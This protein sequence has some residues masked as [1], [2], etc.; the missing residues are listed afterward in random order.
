MT[1]HYN[2]TLYYV[3]VYCMSY[4]HIISDSTSTKLLL[5]IISRKKLRSHPPVSCWTKNSAPQTSWEQ[6]SRLGWPWT[7]GS[8]SA[9]TIKV[10]FVM[11][12]FVGMGDLFPP[13]DILSC[14]PNF[15]TRT[16]GILGKEDYRK[17]NNNNHNNNNNSWFNQMG[18]F[19]SKSFVP[20]K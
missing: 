18:I 4:C 20:N 13:N 9:P 15:E 19:F 8:D 6:I 11:K 10:P 12:R 16:E 2:Y 1:S 5:W 17:K 3:V 7:N 14:I